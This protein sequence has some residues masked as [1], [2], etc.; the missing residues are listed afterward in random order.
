[1][2]FQEKVL[3]RIHQFKPDAVLISAGFDAHRA[4]PLA[5][6]CLS[7]ESFSWMTQRMM[8]IA[9]QYSEGRLISLLE[10]GYDLQALPLCVA[11]HLITLNQS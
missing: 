6:V 1:M 7:T 4:D 9:D 10:G 2:A 11:E 8:E 5:Q 3:P